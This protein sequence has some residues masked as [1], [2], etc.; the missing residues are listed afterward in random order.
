MLIKKVKD[1]LKRVIAKNYIKKVF[2]NSQLPRIILIGSPIHGNLGDHAI[3]IAEK[4]LFQNFSDREFLEIPGLYYIAAP[5]VLK[6]Y[7]SKE[8]VLLITGGGF[9]GTLWMNEQS[10]VE[11]VIENYPN[12]KTIIMPQTFYFSED[13]DGKK[14]RNHMKNLIEKHSDIHIFAREEKS[15]QFCKQYFKSA[16]SIELVPDMVINLNY[17]NHSIDRESVLLCF[18]TD[19]EKV[20]DDTILQELYDKLEQTHLM[21]HKTDTVIH[22]RIGLKKRE[23]YFASKLLEF[24]K[25]KIVITDRLHGMIFAAITGT[26]CIALDNLSHKVKGVYEWLKPLNYIVFVDDPKK[27]VSSIDTLLNMKETNYDL[28]MKYQ[29]DFDKI[30]NLIE[31]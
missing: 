4:K 23:E 26:P 12:N 31:D 22:K 29:K 1:I 7:V 20:L 25:S 2:K 21:I 9:I 11:S 30:L 5:D 8:D 3:S 17:M 10:M 15:Y 28:D 6:R 14:E 18:R 24:Q 13:E 16:N 19:K 27:I